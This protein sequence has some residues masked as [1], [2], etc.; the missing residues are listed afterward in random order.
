[1]SLSVKGLAWAMGL[2]WGGA[3]L[4]CGLANLLFPGYAVGFLDWAASFYPGYDG[5][6]G[7][8]SVIVVTLYGLVDGAVGGFLLAWLY[9]HFADPA[10]AGATPGAADAEPVY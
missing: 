7:F 9:N 10:G 3:M 1:M 5:P 2:L 8:G 6:G 4:L